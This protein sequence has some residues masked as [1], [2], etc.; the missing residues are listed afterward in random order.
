MVRKQAL[1]LCMG[2]RNLDTFRTHFG[3]PPPPLS[4]ATRRSS[5]VWLA[6]FL[7]VRMLAAQA[8]ISKETVAVAPESRPPLHNV[9]L[10]V[11]LADVH[12][13]PI[14]RQQHTCQVTLQESKFS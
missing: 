3:V 5:L 11:A 9:D 13:F 14:I 4:F 8:A 12:A 1:G 6:P 7:T 2:A 10:T